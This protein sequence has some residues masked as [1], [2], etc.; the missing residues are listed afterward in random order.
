MGLKQISLASSS[1]PSAAYTRTTLSVLSSSLPV[2]DGTGRR[3]TRDD[4]IA[5]ME[6]ISSSLPSPDGNGRF[7]G[8]VRSCWDLPDEARMST[9]ITDGCSGCNPQLN[10]LAIQ[11]A[12]SAACARRPI[13]V[14]VTRADGS[15]SAADVCLRYERPLD[16][17][18]IGENSISEKQAEDVRRQLAARGIHAV[19]VRLSTSNPPLHKGTSG[20]DTSLTPVTVQRHATTTD[21][22]REPSAGKLRIARLGP[23]G[24]CDRMRGNRGDGIDSGL[25][26]G[27]LR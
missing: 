11:N 17:C 15:V 14:V 10:N 9:G 6:L 25:D 7:E 22:G 5:W 8:L 16:D 12:S 18:P 26:E 4:F 23:A 27:M 19:H 21:L 20:V 3:C 24:D 2:T 1:P 13:R